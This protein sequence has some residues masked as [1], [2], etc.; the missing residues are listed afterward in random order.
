MTYT[1]PRLMKFNE[2]LLK[3]CKKNHKKIYDKYGSHIANGH[4]KRLI[5]KAKAK[6][7]KTK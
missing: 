2:N 3:Q 1:R 5:D 6:L 4:L 7:I